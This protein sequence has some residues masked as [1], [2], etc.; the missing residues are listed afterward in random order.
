MANN[1]IKPSLCGISRNDF[2]VMDISCIL[3]SPPNFVARTHPMLQKLTLSLSKEHVLVLLPPVAT[4]CLCI[5][6]CHA[7]DV[8]LLLPTNYCATLI[9][10]TNVLLLTQQN[11]CQHYICTTTPSS[12]VLLTLYF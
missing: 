12:F 3:A 2:W 7:V 8:W 10:A 11:C 5:I 4:S 1:L 9:C 6:S